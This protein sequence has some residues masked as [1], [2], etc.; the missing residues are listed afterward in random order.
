[1]RLG[2]SWIF[3][4]EYKAIPEKKQIGNAEY[5]NEIDYEGH[6]VNLLKYREETVENGENRKD[7]LENR[8]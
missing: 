3:A 5:I 1:M 4:K 8:K 7:A 6:K 2:Q